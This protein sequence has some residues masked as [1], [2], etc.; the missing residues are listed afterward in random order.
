MS[1][2]LLMTKLKN[3]LK[4]KGDYGF[5]LSN[6]NINGRK[7]GCSGFV[8]N[9][10]N[11]VVVYVDTEKSCYA[12]LS[13]KNLVRYANSDHDYKGCINEWAT[14]EEVVNKIISMLNNRKLYDDLTLKYK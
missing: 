7:V 9:P 5:K 6:T 14:D 8:I 12:P 4:K 10:N 1:N 3:G 2:V 13:D 11:G